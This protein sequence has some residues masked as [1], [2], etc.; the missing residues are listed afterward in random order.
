[1]RVVLK[2]SE[3]TSSS[4]TLKQKTAALIPR[5]GWQLTASSA[6]FDYVQGRSCCVKGNKTK[7]RWTRKAQIRTRE[8]HPDWCAEW[9]WGKLREGPSLH[10]RKSE[11]IF[12]SRP[13]TRNNTSHKTDDGFSSVVHALVYMFWCRSCPQG[14]KTMNTRGRHMN[15]CTHAYK[16]HK[17]MRPKGF[18]NGFPG[19]FQRC[20][21]FQIWSCGC[22][23][24]APWSAL[25]HWCQS[26][27]FLWR[28][29]S[30]ET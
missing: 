28:E 20:D 15:T 7:K 9:I 27:H 2:F 17:K 13:L 26:Q 23:G 8:K 18:F 19:T 11:I 1:M 22:Y 25:K 21:R 14:K 3:D 29:K 6:W 30:P 5:I 4:S 16:T 10:W 12:C 24:E